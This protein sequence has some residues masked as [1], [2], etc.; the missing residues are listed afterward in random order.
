MGF[1]LDAGRR[2]ARED[3][4]AGYQCRVLFGS[5]YSTSLARL[6]R[7]HSARPSESPIPKRRHTPNRSRSVLLYAA[8]SAP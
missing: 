7:C 6:M 8:P 1:A 4:V 2:R 3:V 5:A